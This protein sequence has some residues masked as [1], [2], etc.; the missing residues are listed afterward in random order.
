[1]TE[2][3]PRSSAAA[4]PFTNDQLAAQLQ[5]CAILVKRGDKGD[6]L[7]RQTI[8]DL[9]FFLT[10]KRVSRD[11]PPQRQQ[12]KQQSSTTSGTTSA[13]AASGASAS[14]G[15]ISKHHHHNGGA[16]KGGISGIT[17]QFMNAIGL[18]DDSSVERRSASDKQSTSSKNAAR[19]KAD[20]E[21]LQRANGTWTGGT[22]TTTSH[23]DEWCETHFTKGCACKKR[24]N[25]SKPAF[26]RPNNPSS[27]LLANGWVEQQRRSK[28]RTVWK[29]VLA[30]LVEG[31]QPGEE[32]TLWIQREVTHAVTHK[33]ELEALHQIPVKWLEAVHYSNY[34]TDHRFVLKVYNLQEE[35]VFRCETSEEA[36]QNWVLTLRSMMEIARKGTAADKKTK[37]ALDESWEE[38]PEEKKQDPVTAAQQQQQKQRAAQQQQTQRAR[39][40][41]PPP[42]SPKAPPPQQPKRAPPPPAGPKPPPP[43]THS[44]PPQP[45]KTATAAAAPPP[46]PGPA[47]S[48]MTVKELR[49]IAHGAGIVTVG[50][51]RGELEHV[52]HLIAGSQSAASPSNTP[53]TAPPQPPAAATKSAAPPQPA[54]AAAASVSPPRARPDSVGS[55]PSASSDDETAAHLRAQ[56]E[57]ARR[58][59]LAE[60]AARARSQTEAQQKA[61]E[62]RRRA[63]AAEQQA[64]TQQQQEAD[65]RRKQEEER[66][67]LERERKQREEEEHRRRVAELQAA[68]QRRRQEEH[69]RQ[70]QQQWQQQ[71]QQWQ[72]QQAEEARRRQ[73]DQQ[74]AEQQRRQQEEAY[75]QWHQQQA[76]AQAAQQP[77]HPQQQQ[78]S[79]PQQQQQQFHPQHSHFQQQPPPP[80]PGSSP[81]NMKYAKM[82]AGGDES[83]TKAQLQT[84]KHGV[85]VEWALQPPAMQILRPIES[86]V[87]SIHSVFPPKFGVA[88]HEHFS[89][90]KVVAMPE[91][92]S[93][94]Q[95]DDEKLK[96]VVKK[97]RFLLHPDK[98]PRDFS[99]EQQFMCRMLWDITHDAFEDHKK[100]EEELGWMKN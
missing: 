58:R 42:A 23:E 2:Q 96:K 47:P 90:W 26:Q 74:R 99:E 24:S 81:I 15:T 7:I 95:P 63:M 17:G 10:G 66:Q 50:M 57:L 75:R 85:L 89:K 41:D 20:L 3:D 14:P 31:R 61:E 21:T 60:E 97:L 88:G 37:T 9:T 78:Q 87:T 35:F 56:E 77:P 29:E 19:A 8:H 4:P 48:R 79:Y 67:K 33:K 16:A 100:K 45:P 32:T 52:V 98:L 94:A 92:M 54:A 83:Q 1:M 72:A 65:R 40:A 70:Q 59:R 44:P 51:E 43:Q 28:M 80:P 53:R 46:H 6:P 12:Q 36:A 68:E 84:I 13:T 22:A 11:P 82:A 64:R 62:E 5:K 86:L 71:Q 93:G 91:V 25:A 30:S 73:A 69:Q 76:R 39:R 34:S 38:F 55:V 27:A 49:A 18:G